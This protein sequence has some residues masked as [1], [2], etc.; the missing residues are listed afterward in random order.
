MISRLTAEPLLCPGPL[1]ST[2]VSSDCIFACWLPEIKGLSAFAGWLRT[3]D[4]SP[5]LSTKRRQTELNKRH[6]TEWNRPSCLYSD[7]EFIKWKMNI[8]M[9]VSPCRWLSVSPCCWLRCT[10][11]KDCKALFLPSMSR[12]VY[13]MTWDDTDSATNSLDGAQAYIFMNGL[14]IVLLECQTICLCSESISDTSCTGPFSAGSKQ[15][16]TGGNMR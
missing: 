3:R 7:C 8:C 13:F 16:D 15:T 14:I 2:Q 9:S 4:C 11:V 5:A 6:I 1:R 10:A 12:H